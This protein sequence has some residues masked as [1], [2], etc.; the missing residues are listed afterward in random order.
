MNRPELKKARKE[1]KVT[2]FLDY[3]EYLASLY[4]S[5][6]SNMRSYSYAQF[7][8]DLGFS[9]S[10]V[11]WLVITGRRKLSGQAVQRILDVLGLSGI[12]RKYFITLVH[13]NNARLGSVR[14]KYQEQLFD[15]KTKELL[16][17]DEQEKL[18]YFGEWYYPVIREMMGSGEFRADPAWIASKLYGK[19]LP[20]EI[21]FS[22]RLLEKLGLIVYDQ[23]KGRYIQAGGQIKP[24]R[25]VGKM[26]SVRFHEKMLD[27]AKESITR[28]PSSRRDYNALTLCISEESANKVRE[29]VREF[30]E[31]VFELEKNALGQGEADQVYQL[32]VQLFPFTKSLSEKDK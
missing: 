27:I 3:K 24:D 7:A 12:E 20:K 9:K 4:Q 28:V 16:I 19:L 22:I 31:K 32:N 21:I 30:C 17:P 13:H 2:A 5:Q 18:E 1:I 23:D 11:I 25:K 26:A 15:L 14:E 29:L 8:E 10:N 6:K